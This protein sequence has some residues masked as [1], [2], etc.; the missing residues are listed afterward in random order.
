MVCPV[1]QAVC[2]YIK[3]SDS[4]APV[5][6]FSPRPTQLRK[7]PESF[8][9]ED[10]TT[11]FYLSYLL[12]LQLDVKAI[13]FFG[14]TNQAKLQREVN[15]GLAMAHF[16]A[17]KRNLSGDRAEQQKYLDKM[18]SLDHLGV[19][20]L[21][22]GS[23][24]P[25]N[26]TPF[27]TSSLPVVIPSVPVKVQLL[28]QRGLDIKEGLVR[29]DTSLPSGQRLTQYAFFD[30]SCYKF[31][32][33]SEV[34]TKDLASVVRATGQQ[35]LKA[36]LLLADRSCPVSYVATA[37]WSSSHWT[38]DP[39]PDHLQKYPPGSN[40]KVDPLFMEKYKRIVSD[41]VG[42]HVPAS[43]PLDS[44]SVLPPPIPASSQS[45]AV[46][47]W[48]TAELLVNRVGQV[49]SIVDCGNYGIAAIKMN[50]SDGSHR[51]ERAIVLFDTCDVWMGKVTVQ[52]MDMNLNQVM[53]KGDYVKVKAILVPQSE[54][55]KNIRYLATSL[56]TGKL[57]RNVVMMKIPEMGPLENFDQ[58]HPS[59]LNNFYTV[60]SAICRAVPGDGED[61]C[62]GVSTDEDEDTP[63][64]IDTSRP[65]PII[66]A[67]FSAKT[68]AKSASATAAVSLDAYET[69]REKKKLAK[70]NE[71]IQQ[72]RKLGYDKAAR[73]KMLMELK[74]KNQILWR[75]SQCN[76]TCG[77]AGMEKHVTSKLHWDNV[78]INFKK[79]ID[80]EQ[81]PVN[82]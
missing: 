59:K 23:Y 3:S 34:R 15:N 7:F 63:P 55:R 77:K 1:L 49:T 54:N 13:N 39:E 56:V 26:N 38:R 9:R 80:S 44:M 76:I 24:Q 30:L 22:Y 47:A 61:E 6:L 35:A 40:I 73:D 66:G 45:P 12:P 69:E 43:S 31:S 51:K 62:I 68:F 36:H 20:T 53:S 32:L 33:K 11:N 2:V 25:I 14:A 72:R 79:M 67:T 10:P 17:T 58:I 27:L 4:A 71:C 8:H 78:L 74:L 82:C 52:Q 81:P 19:R 60:V 46:L 41:I 75:C 21:T 37:L 64:L 42:S 70:A 16:N 5:T 57:K 50:S 48:A 18:S 29:F 28:Y 65:P